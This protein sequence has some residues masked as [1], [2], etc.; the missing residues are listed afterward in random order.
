MGFNERLH[1]MQAAFLAVKLRRLELD[2]DMRDAAVNQYRTR[3]T[4]VADVVM[5]DID[6][7]ADTSTT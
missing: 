5:F 1:E 2:Q 4:D 7:G 3:L 6:P